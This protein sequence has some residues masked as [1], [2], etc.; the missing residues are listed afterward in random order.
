[1]LMAAAIANTEARARA[2]RLADEQAALRRVAM[3]VA[4]A[5]QPAEI[6]GAVSD[7]VG[8]LFGGRAGVVRFEPRGPA[9]VLVGVGKTFEGF[10]VGTRW[11]LDDSWASAEVYRTGRP[12][13]VGTID[14]SS[15]S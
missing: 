13:R 10:P 11:E 9:I 12:A 2:D 5:T 1:E 3:L 4:Q 14:G 15:A 8:R 7:E 6:F